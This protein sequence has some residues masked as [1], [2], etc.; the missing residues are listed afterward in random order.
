MHAKTYHSFHPRGSQAHENGDSASSRDTERTTYATN[1]CNDPKEEK[2]D[3]GNYLTKEDS[4]CVSENVTRSVIS[5]SVIDKR[6]SSSYK[7]REDR[8][9]IKT[10]DLKGISSKYIAPSNVSS[11]YSFDV[12]GEV[13]EAPISSFYSS[14]SK[15]EDLSEATR[16]EQPSDKRES[17][18]SSFYR[19]GGDRKSSGKS[20][21]TE[22]EDDDSRRASIHAASPSG[23]HEI[24]EPGRL[25]KQM[26]MDLSES[27]GRRESL[28]KRV[29][30]E[31][32]ASSLANADSS[33]DGLDDA[34][35][36]RRSLERN[37]AS[38]SLERE[39]IT[40]RFSVDDSNPLK[41]TPST[42]L[43]LSDNWRD[44]DLASSKSPI[45]TSYDR[46]Y[47]QESRIGKVND[48]KR[49]IDSVRLTGK[50][51]ARS[52]SSEALSKEE[53]SRLGI[54]RELPGRNEF[55]SYTSRASSDKEKELAR[56][57]RN[58]GSLERVALGVGRES[59]PLS[60]R[61]RSKSSDE[62]RSLDKEDKDRPSS[63]RST[64]FHRQGSSD[65]RS[66][67]D[68]GKPSVMSYSRREEPST[69]DMLRVDIARLNAE[70]E[71]GTMKKNDIISP[72]TVNREYS[73]QDKLKSDIAKLKAET[74]TREHAKPCIPP[75]SSRIESRDDSATKISRP[76][77]IQDK[78]KEDIAMLKAETRDFPSLS[79]RTS[80]I[81]GHRTGP[82]STVDDKRD[83]HHSGVTTSSLERYAYL[84]KDGNVLR[85]EMRSDEKQIYGDP[86]VG[87]KPSYTEHERRAFRMDGDKIPRDEHTYVDRKLTD[88]YFPR[89]SGNYFRPTSGY[90]D[91][92]FERTTESDDRGFFTRKAEHRPGSEERR[93]MEREDSLNSPRNASEDRKLTD[94]YFPRSSGNYFRPTSGYDD[95]SFERTTESDDR[96]FFT[97]KAEHRPGSEERRLMEREDSLISPRNASEE[98]FRSGR[99]TRRGSTQGYATKRVFRAD[100]TMSMTSTKNGDHGPSS[101]K[102]F[103]C[104][105]VSEEDQSAYYSKEM[106]DTEDGYSRETFREPAS[107]RP[108]EPFKEAFRQPE[109]PRPSGAARQPERHRL[110]E[111]SST[112]Q[113]N[114]QR[115]PYGPTGQTPETKVAS[116]KSDSDRLP[117]SS[118]QPDNAIPL[119]Y[120][121]RES[122]IRNREDSIVL[123]SIGSK[124]EPKRIAK[125]ENSHRIQSSREFVERKTIREA[126]IVSQKGSIED[127]EKLPSRRLSERYDLS[128][129]RTS[130]REEVFKSQESRSRSPNEYVETAQKYKESKPSAMSELRKKIE[131][132][133]SKVDALDDSRSRDKLER[134]V[135]KHSER[136]PHV[137]IKDPVHIP[138]Y[139]PTTRMPERRPVTDGVEPKPTREVSVRTNN[140]NDNKWY[141]PTE[142]KGDPHSLVSSPG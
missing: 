25:V 58:T 8:K 99:E 132:L 44:K 115:Q 38:N 103:F 20:I 140:H 28:D 106:G 129:R 98:P 130:I 73:I 89:S 83:V 60:I 126:S 45:S 113:P 97:R 142:N 56:G 134:Y 27:L 9:S 139:Q 90:D 39:R 131:E 85:D 65:I 74:L 2:V 53:R 49:G 92:S 133:K 61:L 135:D 86:E 94:D 82:D 62:L 79:R 127:V 138:R 68:I 77:T 100:S 37:Q 54:Y 46:D 136:K 72:Y 141:E 112:T 59:H 70:T 63:Y 1:M 52:L 111:L 128:P 125:G 47:L 116:K 137:D 30:I 6:S 110:A 50:A 91:L 101:V 118:K 5:R 88:D 76:S 109:S 21:R 104:G 120:P 95:L 19:S 17:V 31:E 43:S 29:E 32:A 22:E 4:R 13:K 119:P 40:K 124:D 123:A 42:Y 84:K 114:G 24:K 66:K 18:I 93:L 26:D 15:G 36:L 23:L 102:G 12:N 57:K 35:I 51:R 78:L 48:D 16:F 64:Y 33:I 3:R 75:S 14:Y 11:S 96:G 122:V 69:H 108:T 67:Y 105:S 107:S 71:T 81:T 117:E 121:G 34:N 41:Y 87:H 55:L 80:E 7:T 10:R